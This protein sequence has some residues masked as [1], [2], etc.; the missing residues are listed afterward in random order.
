[1]LAAAFVIAVTAMIKEVL[2][3]LMNQEPWLMFAAPFAGILCAVVL[4]HLVAQGKAVQ[5]VSG[6]KAPPRRF[7]AWLRFPASAVRADLTADVVRHAGRE[8]SFPWRLAPIRAAAIVC[9]VGLG[10]PM[11]TESPA[12]H[13]G[14]AAGSAIG[15]RPGWLRSLARPAGLGGGAAGV[16]ALM[17]LPLVG[18]VFMLELGRRKQAALS[19]PRILAAGSGALVGWGFSVAFDLD[20]IRLVVPAIAPGD[21]VKALAT[22]ALVGA[23]SGA[24]GSVTGTAIYQARSWSAGPRTK[25]I[26]GSAVLLGS[27]LAISMLATPAAAIGPGGGTISWAEAT[28]ASVWVILVVALLRC[29]A[30]TA[31]VAAGGVGGLFVPLLAIGDL[32]GRSLAPMLGVSG[33]LGAAAGAAGAIAGGYRQPLTAIT[34]VLTVGGPAPSRLT[35]VVAALVATGT[36][37]LTAYRLD[38]YVLHRKAGTPTAH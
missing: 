38:R 35:C 30:T 2:G 7:T 1:M 29:V 17:G 16:A 26:A 15:G 18:L 6:S 31:A 32:C 23:L 36:G 14:V 33:D 10:A 27:F 11:G 21:L 34:M 22:A 19:L 5:R 12:A 3:W 24:V 28:T 13:L 8:E 20:F 4:L 37:V 9:T 25:L